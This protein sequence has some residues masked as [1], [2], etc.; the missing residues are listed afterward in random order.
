[1]ATVATSRSPGRARRKP[2]KPSRRE[3]RGRVNLW[4]TTV[5][6]LPFAHGAMGAAGTRFSLRPLFYSRANVSKARALTSRDRGFVSMFH[7]A[8]LPGR[9]F[10]FVWRKAA[11]DPASGA[12]P[13][14][15][16]SCF[17]SSC[18][19][20]VQRIALSRTG[21]PPPGASYGR[22]GPVTIWPWSEIPLSAAARRVYPAL[23][24]ENGP[25][26]SK[27]A[28]MTPESYCEA[29]GRSYVRPRPQ[30]ARSRIGLIRA[31]DN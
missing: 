14:C 30:F 1:V 9:S 2:L 12:G 8:L 11:F 22:S 4:S 6:F 13:A 20:S 19:K 7:R 27:T 18:I 17:R 29:L 26:R 28:S 25:R 15:S 23:F 10:A 3:R 24:A 21:Q 5:C 31:C 16:E